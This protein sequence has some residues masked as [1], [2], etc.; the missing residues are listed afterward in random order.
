MLFDPSA[1]HDAI[2]AEYRLPDI[3][4]AVDADGS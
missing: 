2:V 3:N 1:T 4:S